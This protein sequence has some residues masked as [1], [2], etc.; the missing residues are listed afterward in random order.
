MTETVIVPD[1]KDWT[2]VVGRA[3]PECGADVPSISA[4]SVAQEIRDNVDAWAETLRRDPGELRRRPCPDRWS[5]LEYAARVCDVYVLYLE[6]L[7]LMIEEQDPLYPNWDQDAAA[8]SYRVEDPGQVASELSAAAE[9]LA[10]DFDELNVDDW[11][12]P[13]RRSDGARFTVETFARYLLHDPLH[14]L[15][16]VTG[17]RS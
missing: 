2:W 10:A 1:D 4:E 16:D 3:C 11:Q 7:R 12:R 9:A 6:R 5:A 17:Q 15:W 13:G 14:H 8:A